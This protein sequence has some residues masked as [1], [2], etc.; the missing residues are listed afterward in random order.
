MDEISTDILAP[1]NPIVATKGNI[2]II[3]TTKLI[4]VTTETYSCLFTA[5]NKA[6]VEPEIP[7]ITPN[8][9]NIFKKGKI[10]I[11]VSPKTKRITSRVKKSKNVP[12][13]ILNMLISASVL[14]KAF[15][16]LAL[17]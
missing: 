10:S 16:S 17:S 1:I 3:N 6:E 14:K 9:I 13:E 2:V 4:N 5:K 11:Q 8:K 12:N 15:L 7:R